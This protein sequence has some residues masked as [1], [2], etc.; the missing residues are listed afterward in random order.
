MLTVPRR[1]RLATAALL[2]TAALLAGC[3][4]A[5]GKT[6]DAA[7]ATRTITSEAGETTIPTEPK[8]LV[9]LDEPAAL[10]LMS[11]GIK[12]DAVFASWRTTVPREIIEAAG[13]KVVDT[14]EFYPAAEEVA[15]LEPDLI[16]GTWANGWSQSAP[17][18]DE[19]APMIGGLYSAPGDKIVEAYGEYF[20]RA[21]EAQGV[22]AALQSATQDAAAAQPTGGTSL[23]VLMSFG[24]DMP[25]YMDA[26][27]SLFGSIE[28]AG[29]TRPKLQTE[30]P[31]GGSAFGGWSAFSP[32]QLPDHDAQVLAVAV[33]K[34]YSLEGITE[35]PLYASLDAVKQQHS[36]VVDG[37]LWSGGAAFYT[38]WAL[39]DLGDFAAGKLAPGT[40]ADAAARWADFTAASAAK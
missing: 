8:M 37:D 29:F 17:A 38:Y 21:A 25:L 18:Y 13:V 15:A 3:S 27:N 40:S 23:S 28:A 26:D 32:E 16:V 22:V 2:I 14:T 19:I 20:D 7:A 24:G 34:Q 11:I 35:L 12:P 9:A 4:S 31:E 5:P 39:R 33:A 6:A 36:V 30:H 1:G 10:N